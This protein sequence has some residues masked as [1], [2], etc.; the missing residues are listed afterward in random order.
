MD[1]SGKVQSV[2]F[3]VVD[4]EGELV[5]VSTFFRS[6]SDCITERNQTIKHIDKALETKQK[7]NPNISEVFVS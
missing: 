3:G 6:Q 2:V 1:K 5:N 4:R 7:K